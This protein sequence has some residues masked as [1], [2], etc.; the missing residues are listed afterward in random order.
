VYQ[1]NYGVYGA[2]KTWAA[3]RRVGRQVARCTVERLMRQAGLTGVVPGKNIRTT[4]AAPAPRGAGPGAARLHCAGA[5]P[6]LGRGLHPRGHLRRRRVRGARRRVYSRAFVGWSAATTKRTTLVLGA[7]DMG[8]WRRDPWR[9]A[10]R[11]G[12]DS[13]LGCRIAVHVVP[14]HRHLIATGI[15]AFIGTVGGALDNELMESATGLYKPN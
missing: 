7:L 6:V 15:D 8:L 9:P 12:P 14:V 4:I 3:L 5:E 1:A 11:G 13:P 2:R 10:R